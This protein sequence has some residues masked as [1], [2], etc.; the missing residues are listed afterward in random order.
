MP[1][2]STRDYNRAVTPLEF[3]YDRCTACGSL[4]LVDPPTDLAP[5]YGGDYF[6]LPTPAKLERLARAE[7]YKLD[8]LRRHV[9]AGRVVEA[10][11]A[12]G[13]REARERRRIRLHRD[14]DGRPLLRVPASNT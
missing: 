2:L 10:G 11:P 5:Y 12:S 9:T 13:V 8:F 6:V 7:T 14:R 3:R 1:A 4:F